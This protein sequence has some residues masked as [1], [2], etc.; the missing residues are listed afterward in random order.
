MTG[1]RVPTRF[2]ADP[3]AA[4]LLR[5]LL[6]QARSNVPSPEDLERIGTRVEAAI[7]AGV[8]AP[9]IELG[10]PPSP[11]SLG[12]SKALLVGASLLVGAAIVATGWYASR[13][14]GHAQQPA[15]PANSPAPPM[16]PSAAPNEAEPSAAPSEVDGPVVTPSASATRARDPRASAPSEVSLLD[17]ARSEL[18]RNPR[19]ALALTEEHRRRFPSGALVQEREVI[20]IEALSRLGQTTDARSRGSDFERRYPGSA[21]RQKV[22]QAT[23]GQ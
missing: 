20:A 1:E 9:E 8:P 2:T 5:S 4:P 16:T 19:R 23:R 14:P 6:S 22:D 17:Q 18:D 12:G 10:S 21:H 15:V 3:G 7:A 11:A 13:G